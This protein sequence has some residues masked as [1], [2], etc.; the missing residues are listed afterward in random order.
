MQQNDWQNRAWQQPGASSPQPPRRT[1]DEVQGSPQPSSQAAQGAWAPSSGS[2]ASD[3][4]G[5]Q[6]AYAYP[7]Q[8]VPAAYAS[9]QPKKRGW[10]VALVAVV[11]LFIVTIFGMMSCTNV[12]SGFSS[13]G[14]SLDE[15]SSLVT[16]GPSV[17]VIEISGTIQYD[18]SVCSPEGLKGKLDEAAE[19][20]NIK[21][22]V[23]RVDS[24]G[25]VATAGEEMTQYV[26][27]F[28]KPVVVSSASMNASAAY[29]ISSQADY[30]YTAKTS[31]IGAIGT[32]MQITDLSG[33][34]EKLGI[35]IEDITSA[36][37]KDSSYGTRGLTDEERAHYQHMVDQINET[38]LQSVAEGR[39]MDIE[40]VRALATGMTFTGMDAVENGLADEIGTLETACMKAAELGGI[41]NTFD[42]VYLHDEAS[43]LESL[44]SLENSSDITDIPNA[45]KELD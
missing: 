3:I 32:A 27:D 35:N 42:T 4:P 7:A 22:I 40:E 36:E 34:Y 37:G 21:A 29:E 20:P 45:M 16:T 5:G 1:P 13:L 24:G 38:F 43:T 10:I 23:L 15:G 30:I 26:K 19:D 39:G 2:Q 44:F 6:Q 31:A 25:G 18:G 28:S 11:L 17:G 9:P 33:L 14:S 41:G 8:A 12:L